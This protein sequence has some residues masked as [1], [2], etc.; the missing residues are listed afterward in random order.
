MPGRTLGG[1]KIVYRYQR[2]FIL[3][4]SEY[5]TKSELCQFGKHDIDNRWQIFQNRK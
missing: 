3:R 2:I 4:W 5:N 1:C